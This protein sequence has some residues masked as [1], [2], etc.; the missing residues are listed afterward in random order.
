MGDQVQGTEDISGKI[1]KLSKIKTTINENFGKPFLR[2]LTWLAFCVVVALVPVG[3][4]GLFSGLE[5]QAFSIDKALS[6]LLAISIAIIGEFMGYLLLDGEVGRP[7]KGF[8]GAGG[9]LIVIA[10][11]LLLGGLSISKPS[12]DFNFAMKVAIGLF[13]GTLFLGAVCKWTEKEKK[14]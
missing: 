1:S 11:A 5:H 8:V 3:S 9:L 10:S 6:D 13:V 4:N 7:V 12:D 14:A 2:V